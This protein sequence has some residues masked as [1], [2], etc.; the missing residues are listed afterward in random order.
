MLRRPVHLYGGTSNVKVLTEEANRFIDLHVRDIKACFLY[1]GRSNV[2]VLTEEVN[3][4]IDLH[5]RDV[6]ACSSTEVELML[7]Y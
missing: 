2:K 4:F 3:R 6:K 1:G 5:V 7:R